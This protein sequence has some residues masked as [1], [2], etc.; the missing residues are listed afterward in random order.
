MCDN[1]LQ[2]GGEIIKALLSCEKVDPNI[3]CI[4]NHYFFNKI[5]IIK[6]NDIKKTNIP[7]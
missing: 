5:L 6:I 2:N 7:I 4:F 1:Y 3:I